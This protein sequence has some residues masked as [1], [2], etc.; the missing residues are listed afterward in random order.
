MGKLKTY[1]EQL[2]DIVEKGI[3]A[4]EEQQKKLA[5]KPF[6]YAEKLETEAREY[7][8][9]TLRTRYYGYSENL[10]EQLRSL[11]TRFGS[12]AADL[13]AKLEKEA[14]EGADTVADA[15][16]EVTSVA[17]STKA[18]A[19]AKKPAARKTTARKSTSTA[20]KSPATA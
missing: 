5:S 9:K 20:K 7:S 17:Q 16:D 12:F 13:V 11:N 10:F 2:Q 6:E 18:T 14:A 19:Q 3:N 15:A 1:Q 4:A 8:V